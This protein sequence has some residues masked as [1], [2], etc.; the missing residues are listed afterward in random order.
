[1]EE[2]RDVALQ[3]GQ[4]DLPFIGQVAGTAGY[5][6]AELDECWAEV[7]QQDAHLRRQRLVADRI[8]LAIQQS[9]H[10]D[11]EARQRRVNQWRCPRCRGKWCAG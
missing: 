9:L 4:L 5:D 6:L 8:A 11:A 1:M 10:V 3:L 7:L 2:G